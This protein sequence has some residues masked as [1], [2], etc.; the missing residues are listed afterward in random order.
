MKL[1]PEWAEFIGLLSSHRV[2]FVVVGAH[3]L[4]VHGLPRATGD[5]DLFVEPSRRNA[6]RLGAALAAFG[7]TALARDA[8]RFAELDRMATLGSEPLRIDIM[9]TI[10][11]VDFPTAWRNRR[12][13]RLGRRT[14]GFLGR[15]DLLRNKRTAG[16]PQDLVDV[17]RLTAARKR[18]RRRL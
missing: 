6:A 7:F 1:P 3:A 8:P 13:V 16:R 12:R 2:R 11:G 5:L 4:A 18:P 17:L 15:R 9:T 10:S 14:V